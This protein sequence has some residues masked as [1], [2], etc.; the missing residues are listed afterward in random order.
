MFN[1]FL[2][3][4]IY[5]NVFIAFCAAFSTLAT[6]KLL[7]TSP[8][9]D[10]KGIELAFF[11]GSATFFLYNLHKPVTY[12]LRKQFINNQRFVRTKAFERPLSILS[13]LAFVFC[14]YYFF[15]LN[16][17][18]Q[19]LLVSMGILSFAYVLPVLGNG[20]RLRDVAFLKIFLIAV[21]WSAVVVGL[22]FL[23]LNKGEI[24]SKFWLLCLER[25]SFIF[26]LCIP[27]DIRDMEW[28]SQT[29]V[30]T[31]PLSIGVKKAKITSFMAL[32]IAIFVDYLLFKKAT[33]NEMLYF[34]L[35]IIYLITAFVVLKT[36]KNHSDYYFY[37]GV[38][39]MILWHSWA[40]LIV[41]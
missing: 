7:N 35:I 27:F 30:K 39:G 26:A 23:T 19:I 37:G 22:P 15:Q 28:D 4:I 2:D 20:R 38:D 6:V 12:F 14:T 13:I 24:S 10:A 41:S 40:F 34:R 17:A 5:G 31:I 18:A 8:S 21:V 25:S 3:F 1:R 11:V 29:K 9:S 36:N 33:Y 16:I 32:T